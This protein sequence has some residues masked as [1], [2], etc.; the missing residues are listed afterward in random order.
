MEKRFKTLV[1]L[2]LMVCM[3]TACGASEVSSSEQ[4]SQKSSE[5]D[6]SAQT[7][8]VQDEQQ[9]AS[10]YP[11]YLNMDGARP[12]V[13]E[14]E[15]ITLKIAIVDNTEA[16]TDFE[17]R[18]FYK[19]I[20]E[21]L[22]INLDVE[23]LTTENQ[24]ER[25]NLMLG[26][27]DL[28]DMMFSLPIGHAEIVEYGV[29]Q[30]LL[31]PV[32]DYVS[33]ELTPNLYELLEENE[34]AK[35]ASIAPDGKIYAIPKIMS[36]QQGYGASLPEMKT[37]ID[38]RYM[39][40][41]GITEVPDTIDEFTDMLRKIKALDPASMGVE[42][43]WPF[44]T[45]S[46]LDGIWLQ[47][48]FGWI[49][50][51][52]KTLCAPVWDVEKEEIV[53]PC[54]TEAYADYVTFLNTLYTEGLIHP[55]YFNMSDETGRAL[56][57]EGSVAVMSDWAP[58]LS[59]PEEW[60]EYLA[61]APL[62]SKWNEEGVATSGASYAIGTILIS[63]DTEY[64]ELCMRLLDYF[65]SPEG[66]VYDFYGAPA[67]SEDTLGVI[68]GY[69]ID[70]EEGVYCGEKQEEY[71]S[72]AYY[73]YN[74]VNFLHYVLNE[75]AMKEAAWE[76]VGKEYEPTELDITGADPYYRYSLIEA[77]GDNMQ[78]ALPAAYMDGDISARYGD[79]GTVITDYVNAETAKFVVGQRPLSELDAYY[80]EL[81]SLGID[82]YM[83]IIND[84][85]AN[86]ERP[87]K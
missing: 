85:Y 30:E 46:K 84:L 31:L 34:E 18:F 3:I 65:Y 11:E 60:D 49:G 26:A 56:M 24:S 81:K 68:E 13:K 52:R 54:M 72:R 29:E 67:G 1:A 37:F 14:G 19:F 74:E 58:Y 63:A 57:A 6:A 86:Y 47:N 23:I 51:N 77:A 83:G 45:C 39:D 82:E 73:L 71:E 10:I 2:G 64:P 80:E 4:S 76:L 50:N 12:I 25:T 9:E 22:N 27:A 5:Q 75:D 44:V 48:T 78:P 35:V 66:L 40:A 41:V 69:I 59:Q 62:K 70:D 36:E 87:T 28:P 21:K 16:L 43:I 32:S 61:V 55:D 7:S 38:T 20:E 33:Q 15:E 17:D 42:E 8:S 53:L 79:L